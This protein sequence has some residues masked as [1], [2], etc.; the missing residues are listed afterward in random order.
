[1]HKAAIVP[2]GVLNAELTAPV[3]QIIPAAI[4]GIA[5]PCVATEIVRAYVTRHGAAP[6]A[7]AHVMLLLSPEN[8]AS[9]GRSRPSDS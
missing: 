8:N 9:L 6:F 5:K 3:N 2:A 7:S 4:A 1:M